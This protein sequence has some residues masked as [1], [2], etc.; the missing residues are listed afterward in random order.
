MMLHALRRN[1]GLVFIV[2]LLGA[3]FYHVAIDFKDKWDLR[4]SYYSHGY[5]ILP[6]SAFLV[7]RKRG[8]L[9]GLGIRPSS[10]GMPVL[11]VGCL[12]RLVGAFSRINFLSGFALIVV[13]LGLVLYLWGRT[14]TWK[15]LFPVLFLVAM[16]PAPTQFVNKV[17][18]R[19]KIA[20]AQATVKI[21]NRFGAGIV[22]TGSNLDFINRTNEPDKLVVGDVCSG[23]RSLIALVAFGA[24]FAYISSVS[25][26]KKLVLFLAAMPAAF[27]ANWVRI[28]VITLIAITWGSPAAVQVNYLQKIGL[29]SI[30]GDWG[31]MH[32]ITGILIYVVAFIVLFSLE[33][34]LV[35]LGPQPKQPLE[36]P[37]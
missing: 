23:L 36:Q 2:L 14:V 29:G 28:L 11:V 9:A 1:L 30:A 6:I 37:A 26:W 8:E 32:D 19:M 15:L 5:L 21:L 3:A 16:V 33:K 10:G 7:Y 24:L 12:M 4:D 31:T 34:L 18:F 25:L 17:S 35:R 13:V 27:I 22:R 20:A